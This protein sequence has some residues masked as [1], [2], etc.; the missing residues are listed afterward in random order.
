MNRV[1][2][3]ISV[4]GRKLQKTEEREKER[5]RSF[6]MCSAHLIWLGSSGQEDEM[7]ESCG[8]SREKR[9]MYRVLVRKPQ[10]KEDTGLKL[11]YNNTIDLKKIGWQSVDWIDLSRDM[12]KWRSL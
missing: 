11:E 4:R 8:T 6:V 7:G 3:K 10:G 9:N 5:E 12:E 2:R 1:L